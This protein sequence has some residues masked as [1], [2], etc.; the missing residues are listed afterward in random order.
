MQPIGVIGKVQWKKGE[1]VQ[2]THAWR[3]KGENIWFKM[4]TELMN[5]YIIAPYF[6]HNQTLSNS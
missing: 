6:T 3:T 5:S 1:S 2:K 4:P